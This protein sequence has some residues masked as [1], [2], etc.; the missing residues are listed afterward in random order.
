[1]SDLDLIGCLFHNTVLFVSESVGV[2]ACHHCLDLFRNFLLR[3][4]GGA[5][6]SLLVKI[7]CLS[8]KRKWEH[9][10]VHVW[11]CETD[12]S[13]CFIVD[14]YLWITK[15]LTKFKGVTRNDFPWLRM[16][17]SVARIVSGLIG[18][19]AGLLSLNFIICSWLFVSMHANVIL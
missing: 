1:M 11:I 17:N 6:C 2:H 4:N 12:A 16:R 9:F 19:S 5:H 15:L 7:K 3:L 18:P 10:F 13:V 8:V 14:K